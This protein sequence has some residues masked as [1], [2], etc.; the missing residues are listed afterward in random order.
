MIMFF[1]FF[2]FFKQKTA[3][4]MSIGDWS[5]DVCSSDLATIVMDDP[6][7]ATA[8][9]RMAAAQA[10]LE[11]L[12]A[13]RS[14]VGHHTRLAQALHLARERVSRAH[15]GRSAHR[16]VLISDG[17]VEDQSACLA[18]LDDAIENGLVI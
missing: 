9:E 5:S 12:A 2:F 7:R 4:E 17:H 3:Y 11:P 10:A 13:G 1:F 8:P 15:A 14:V 16:A 6:G 18:L